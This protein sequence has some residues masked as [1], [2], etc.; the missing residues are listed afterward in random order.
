MAIYSPGA[1]LKEQEILG[2]SSEP[3]IGE[4]GA[5]LSPPH[6][7]SPKHIEDPTL[8]L[9]VTTRDTKDE[10]FL[11]VDLIS[12]HLESIPIAELR[13]YLSQFAGYFRR[14][15]GRRS[16][17]RHLIGLLS[18]I[19]RKN[20][21]Q[22][23]LAVADTNSQRLQALLTELHWDAGAV[24]ELRVQ[25]LIREAVVRSGTL[26]CG[27]TEMQKQGQS[28]VGVARQ[29]VHSIDKVKNCQ[30]LL[31]WHY[32]DSAFSWPVNARLYLPG[33]W[34]QNTQRCQRAR[35]PEGEL[36]FL[37]KA[38]IALRLLDEATQWG[39]PYRQIATTA[40]YGSESL[41]LE[42]LEQRKIEYLVSVPEDFTVQMARRR[43]PA[44]EP[45]R[46]IIA[47]LSDEAWQPIAWPRGLGYGKRTMWARVMGW[48][49]T[50]TGPGDF[51]WLVA[52]R[53]SLTDD[54][55]LRYY[56]TNVNMQT[57][58]STTAR[59]ARRTQRLE[60]FYRFAK[61][62]LGW[63]QYE[64]RLWHGLHRH[65]LLVFLAASFLTLYHKAHM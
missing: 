61:N 15:E 64:G 19:E 38:E 41:F 14:S 32:V 26:I 23:A 49:T 28:S 24:N 8:G 4:R 43:D 46:D 22:I 62:D 29:Y 5:E 27:E 33:E 47:R 9:P 54:R 40:A 50:A 36:R 30:L 65:T 58:L 55:N 44:G 60:E 6:F 63:N 13:Q 51:G 20:E 48:R 56:F 1:N 11:S 25:Q 21:E 12:R 57:S 35:V 45:V 16:L 18:D 2:R 31:S 3:P 17:E 37:A 59:L 10:T 53:P 7:F 34:V 52:E 42:G 39:V